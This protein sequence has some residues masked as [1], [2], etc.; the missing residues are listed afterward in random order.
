M[1]KIRQIDF[2][3]MINERVWWPN[4]KGERFEGKIKSWDRTK[5][6]ATVEMDDGTIEEIKC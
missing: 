5:E 4:M 2:A 1:K 6:V 3:C